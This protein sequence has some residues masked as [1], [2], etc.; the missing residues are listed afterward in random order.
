MV[1]LGNNEVLRDS[2]IYII[3]EIGVNHGCSIKKAKKMIYLAKKGGAS[4]AKFQTYKSEM[5][6]SKYSPAY[7][8]TKKEKTKSQY[9]LF[10]KFDRFERKDYFSLAKYC[11][12]L[13][14]DFLST[15][16]DSDAVDFLNDLMPFYKVASADITNVPMLRQIG[17]KG[18]PVI[19]ST[20]A[21]FLSEVKFAYQTLLESGATDIVP[22]HCVLSYPTDYSNAN[23]SALIELADEFPNQVIGYSDHTLADPGMTVLTTAYQYGARVIEKHFTLDKNIPG[24]DHKHSMD[25]K[26]LEVFVSNVNL[27]SRIKGESGRDVYDCESVSR[28]NARRSIVLSR[29][30]NSGHVLSETDITYKRP[31]FGI[32]T[33][34]WDQVIGQKLKQAFPRD[35]VLT[36]ED[37]G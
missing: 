11:K 6:A 29:D 36:W 14:I 22:L 20:G 7:W 2:G 10:K 13:K 27:I 33:E 12:K 23:L 15:P 4:A 37:I 1:M 26:D 8:D 31:A 32:G 5:I 28:I 3:A 21:S 9:L 34:Y 18:K 19:F 24:G 30:L 17:K 25:K 35:H 16:F